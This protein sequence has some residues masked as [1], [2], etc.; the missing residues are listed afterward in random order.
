MELRQVASRS[1]RSQRTR[2]RILEAAA[3]AFAAGGYAK[4]TVEEIA[5]GAGISKALVYRHFEGK[6]DVLQAVLENTL[7]EWHQV[8]GIDRLAEADSVLEAIAHVQRATVEY[9]RANPLLRALFQ[10]DMLVVIGL[11]N[12]AVR[13]SMESFRS[14]LQVGLERG[15]AT[16]EIRGDLDPKRIN[17][18]VHLLYMALIDHLLNPGWIDGV[19]AALVDT[20]LEVL[21]HGIAGESRR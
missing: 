10:L 12:Q 5:A 8:A 13:A 15:I 21:F 3:R 4:T 6:E 18:V 17:D 1:P 9:A 11:G 20:S 2:G 16:G 7:D 14:V 19:D